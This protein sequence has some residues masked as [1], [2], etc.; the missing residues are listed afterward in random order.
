MRGTQNY[1]T[2]YDPNDRLHKLLDRIGKAANISEL[3]NGEPVGINPN[4][5]RR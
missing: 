1:E 4:H 2:K 5:P 3:L